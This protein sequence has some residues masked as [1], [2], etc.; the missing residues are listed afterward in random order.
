MPGDAIFHGNGV[1]LILEHKKIPAMIDPSK[2]LTVYNPRDW[3]PL[4]FHALGAIISLIFGIIPGESIL[5]VAAA[6]TAVIPCMLFSVTYTKT[7]STIFSL[8]P[9]LAGFVV[10]KPYFLYW[11]IGYFYNGTY[12]FLAGLLFML[13][14]VE[15]I[16]LSGGSNNS[17]SIMI[18]SQI[19]ILTIIISIACIF[20]Y[21]VFIFF[22]AFYF[23]SI[24]IIQRKLIFAGITSRMRR[25]TI[26][27][28]QIITLSGLSLIFLIILLSKMSSTIFLITQFLKRPGM[29]WKKAY[30]SFLKKDINGILIVLAFATIPVSILKWKNEELQTDILFLCTS[31]PIFLTLPTPMSIKYLGYLLPERTIMFLTAFS[32]IIFARFLYFTSDWV[33]NSH[34]PKIAAMRFSRSAV[35]FSIVVI[36]LMIL[37]SFMPSL[38]AHLSGG[39]YEYGW[40]AM[41]SSFQFDSEAAKWMERNIPSQDLILNDLS[42]VS[43]FLPS[44]S[45][46]NVVFSRL[47]E[48]SRAIEC[49]TIWMTPGKPGNFTLLYH[50]I[51]KYEIKYIFTTSEWG[52]FDWWVWEGD[53][54]YKSKPLSE[55]Y[56]A[57]KYDSCPFLRVRFAIYATRVYEVVL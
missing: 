45:V 55:L 22:I 10:Y 15:L 35:I 41:E 40:Y 31:V 24:L 18:P 30:L 21:T 46:N 2:E 38:N 39:L 23:L 3:Y 20:T 9:Y 54:T 29:F 32:W 34:M 33:T 53:G 28:F 13:A 56:Y 1:S 6:I 52:F 14:F 42:W 12:P 43:L 50:L 49:K 11:I 19:F 16:S 57:Q 5:V 17:N 37:R 4:G 27:K 47:S 7:H 26:N 25:L 8:I 51:E 48:L 44:F 36:Y